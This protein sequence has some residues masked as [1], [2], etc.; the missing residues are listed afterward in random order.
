MH[1]PQISYVILGCIDL[2][3]LEEGENCIVFAPFLMNSLSKT[4]P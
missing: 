4:D 3:F 1:S 2:L